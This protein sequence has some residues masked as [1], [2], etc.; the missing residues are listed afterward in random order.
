MRLLI[1]GINYYPELTGIGKYTAEMC[2]WLQLQGHEV[3]VITGCP[4]YPEWRIH[5]GFSNAFKKQV[6]NGVLVYRN[7]LYI[8]E[9]LTGSKRIL[10]EMTFML[11]SAI[12]WF[13]MLFRPSFEHI[14]CVAPPFH[15]GLFALIYR[16]LKG[17]K[18]TYHI[19]DLQVDAARE[20]KIIKNQK[21]LLSIE[22]VEKL[23][24]RKVDMISTI[25]EGMARKIQT[26]ILDKQI[27]Q[28][29]NWV[30][31]SLMKPLP[32][33][34]NLRSQFNIS[35]DDFVVLYS[36]NLGEKQGL[37]IIIT[38]AKK[39]EDKSNIKFLICGNGAYKSA[40]TQ[41]AED[42]QLTN[43][44]FKDLQ[45]LTL[46]PRLLNTGDIHLVL[47]KRNAADLVL[48]SKLTGIA[49]CGGVPIVTAEKGTSLYDTVDHHGIGLLIEPENTE[50]LAK[51]ILECCFA[52][53]SAYKANARNY[54]ENHLNKDVILGQFVEKLK[55]HG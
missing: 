8:P 11:S 34:Q 51:T 29:P 41:L 4:Y 31:L 1:Y 40:L 20:L 3:S 21:L 30:D 7:P 43:V 9:K 45:P 48:P 27:I 52:D 12:T 6:I 10:H 50:S 55:V 42:A 32:K 53:L 25:S 38:T 36:G 33:S 16:R 13:S 14:I 23:I 19:Q 15:S 26:K 47:Q 22:S 49:A 2:E 46:L 35:E 37:D 5:Q 28:L 39:L 44:I 17:G 18:I 54:A 24:L